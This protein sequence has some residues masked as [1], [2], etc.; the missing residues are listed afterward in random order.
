MR[1]IKFSNLSPQS[2]GST[3]NLC[4]IVQATPS[5]PDRVLNRH[6]ALPFIS[7]WNPKSWVL[8]LDPLPPSLLSPIMRLLSTIITAI[9][10]AQAPICAAYSSEDNPV[11]DTDNDTHHPRRF[12][13]FIKTKL[14]PKAVGAPP[15]SV[16]APVDWDKNSMLVLGMREMLYSGEFHPFRL[17]VPSL[18]WDVLEKIRALGLNTVSFFVP[19]VLHEGKPGEFTYDGLFDLTE[20]FAA[21]KELELWLIAKPGPYIS[22][23]SF[24]DGRWAMTYTGVTQMPRFQGAA[25]QGGFK[26]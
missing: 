2:G 25:C 24:I 9:A 18:W 1:F 17:P 5:R 6:D 16:K 19:W 7:S 4:I 8:S 11:S 14:L 23:L 21:A 15:P 10:L 22:E 12:L 20:F 13:E 3:A 26:G